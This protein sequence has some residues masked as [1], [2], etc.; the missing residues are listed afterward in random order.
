M[1]GGDR[2]SPAIS[3]G[4]VGGELARRQD[5]S[6][7][8]HCLTGGANRKAR[9]TPIASHSHTA[10]TPHGFD[11]KNVVVLGDSEL[12]QKNQ[13]CYCIHMQLRELVS[14]NRRI[15]QSY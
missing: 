14:N 3:C 11:Q 2:K 12:I 5:G 6:K 1:V 10:V 9:R 13:K 7:H 8:A 4:W 15:G